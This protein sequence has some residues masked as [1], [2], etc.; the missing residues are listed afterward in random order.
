MQISFSVPICTQ[1]R[2]EGMRNLKIHT[3]LLSSKLK[4]TR[5]L[6]DELVSF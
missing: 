5:A 1:N 2:V 3:Q 4:F 6:K